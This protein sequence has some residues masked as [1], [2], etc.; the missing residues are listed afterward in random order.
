M[1]GA[2]AAADL[3]ELLLNSDNVT[4]RSSCASAL[5]QIASNHPQV[6]FPTASLQGLKTALNDPN[7]LVSLAS[8]NAL[9]EIGAPALDILIESLQTI[10][11]PALAVA[12]VNAL[13]TIGDSRG[14]DVLTAVGNDESA[15]SYVRE[16]AT[17]ALSRL[18]LV[19]NNNRGT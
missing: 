2:D 16:S 19:R 10:D 1:I 6:P 14:V 15:D 9:G 3:V 18:E 11:N 12:I 4:V 5:A 7:P 13:A 17:S 8:V